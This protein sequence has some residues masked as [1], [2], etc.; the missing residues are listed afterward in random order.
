MNRVHIFSGCHFVHDSPREATGSNSSLRDARSPAIGVI[1]LA[2]VSSSSP[3][4][5]SKIIGD[6]TPT[7]DEEEQENEATLERKIYA[8]DY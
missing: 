5:V 4:I 1:M 3:S 2:L 7:K 8:G 6:H